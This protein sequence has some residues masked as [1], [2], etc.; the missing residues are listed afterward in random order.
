MKI[1]N[2]FILGDSMVKHVEGWKLAKNVD[3][4]HKV[5]VRSFPS[6]KVKCM[7]DYVKLCIRE[8]NLDH[9]IIHVSAN[10]LDSERQAEMIPKSIKKHKN[11]HPQSVYKG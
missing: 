11:K 6:V 3:R 1:K 9:V 5:Y 8:N 10:E 7:K 4:K 2:I